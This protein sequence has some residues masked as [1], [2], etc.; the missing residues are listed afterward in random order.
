MPGPRP[1]ILFITTD[2]TNHEMLG[3]PFGQAHTPR[4]GRLAS[5]G[6]RATR[7][8][9]VSTVCTPSRYAW[10]TGHYA[11][12]CPEAGFRAGI[13]EGEPSCITWNTRIDPE[14]E[15]C[16]GHLLQD[17]GYRTGWVGKNHTSP[18]G[19][20]WELG[21]DADP[22]DPT[23]AT[24]L[25]ERYAA[26]QA[27]VRA[28]GF[29]E[30]EGLII[31]NPDNLPVT[32]L[33]AHNLDWM[34][35]HAV[36]FLD[37]A[38][39]DDRPFFLNLAAT[40]LHGPHHDHAGIRADPRITPAGYREE[41]LD[42]L[43]PRDTIAA[44]LEAAGVPVDH[45]TIG[46]LWT[47]DLVGRVLDRLEALGLAE[48]TLVI[49]SAD[50]GNHRLGR[51]FGKATCYHAGAHIPFVARWPGTL[52]AGTTCDA[53]LQNVDLVPTCLALAGAEA[54]TDLVCDGVDMLSALRGDASPPR[55]H[56]Y[57][58]FGYARAVGDGRW[59]YI[60]VRPPSRLVAT[61]RDGDSDLAF[62]YAGGNRGGGMLQY[63]AYPHYWEPD[64][65]YDLERDPD[66]Q[67]NLVDDPAAQ[68]RLQELRS[69][70]ARITATFPDPFE[71]E[72]V[73]PWLHSEAYRELAA[74]T[75]VA[76]DPNEYYWYREGAY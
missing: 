4:I 53:L 57:T 23:V 12:R 1:N 65:L 11:G 2:D 75:T 35:H 28:C 15:R 40:T 70:L 50:H 25:A 38:S 44:R 9:A 7:F 31:G 51:C 36:R 22:A 72:R 32:A 10:L 49:Y 37:Q 58:E 34:A 46:A 61:M 62:D 5:E 67:H 52:P 55:E 60:A 63:R 42:D 29:E 16:I 76:K 39:G 73:D 24:V 20:R 66:Q 19:P 30:V 56:W 54:P 69:A 3:P 64:Q 27:T 21:A 8:H 68:P 45:L 71:L 13:A 33:Q 14:R 48:N 47:D 59:H 6:V 41:H 74:A 43:L 26:Q 18:V 17:A